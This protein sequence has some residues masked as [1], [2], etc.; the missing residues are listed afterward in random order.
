MSAT[1]ASSRR[2]QVSASGELRFV[3]LADLDGDGLDE[4]LVTEG[5]GQQALVGPNLG[6]ATFGPLQSV[7]LKGAGREPRDRKT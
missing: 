7:P 2:G 5:G 3:E 6:A 4:L 1:A